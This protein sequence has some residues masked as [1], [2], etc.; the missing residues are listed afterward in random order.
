MSFEEA[1]VWCDVSWKC[2]FLSRKQRMKNANTLYNR[3]TFVFTLSSFLIKKNTE[4]KSDGY[5]VSNYVR[6]YVTPQCTWYLRAYTDME[7]W[8]VREIVT[9]VR[10]GVVYN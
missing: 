4:K 3:V 10:A 6:V 5:Y 7:W 2:D 9:A 8:S 1:A